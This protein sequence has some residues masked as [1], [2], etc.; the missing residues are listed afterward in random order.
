MR[1][2]VR[3]M[4][5][6]EYRYEDIGPEYF[7]ALY[8]VPMLSC[9]RSTMHSEHQSSPSLTRWRIMYLRDGGRHVVSLV[10]KKLSPGHEHEVPVYQ[11]LQ[12]NTT[13]N[14]PTLIDFRNTPA[15]NNCWILTENCYNYK[16]AEYY[17]LNR[18]FF[19]P[20]P[21]PPATEPTDPPEAFLRPLADLHGKTLALRWSDLPICPIPIHE[22]AASFALPGWESRERA[23]LHGSMNF[24]ETG[25]RKQPEFPPMWCLFDWE[26]A[27]IG[28][29]Y[30]DLAQ[31]HYGMSKPIADESLSWYLSE[32]RALSG[33]TIEPERARQGI[34][35]ARAVL[36]L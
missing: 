36:N 12:E 23:V 28:P 22:Q 7:A 17:Y 10:A 14:M 15:R 21:W 18:L 3:S 4:A 20:T 8:G 32:L 19:A 16:D 6:P 13:V 2:Q 30:L 29:I 1:P 33:V 26:T 35:A 25:F 31:V 34:E 27:R 24:Q 5:K 11:W 9:E